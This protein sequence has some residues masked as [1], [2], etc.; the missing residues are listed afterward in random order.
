MG[1]KKRG[2][3]KK[4]FF[5]ITFMFAVMFAIN[6]AS[7]AITV[8]YPLNY[9]NYTGAFGPLVFFNVSYTNGTDF[10]DAVNATF[11][12]NLTGVW[13]KLGSATVCSRGATASSCN[14]SLNLSGVTDG[15]YSINATL[16][17]TTTSGA[18][19]TNNYTL[20]GASVV[21]QNII[22]DSTPPVVSFSGITN[23]INNGNYSQTMILNVSSTSPLMPISSVYFNITNSTGNQVN[24]TKASASGNYFNL[25]VNTVGFADGLYNVTVFS[26]DTLNN[27][28]NTGK[29]QIAIVNT[30]PIVSFS[31]ITN[32][33]NN[34][35]YS[36]TMVLNV[37][38]N[39]SSLIALSSVYFN[40]TNSSGTQIN[41]TK[42][43]AIGNY[44]NLSVNTVGFTDGLYN[45]TVFSNDTLNNLNNT[46]KIQFTIDNTAPTGTLTCSPN[47]IH[48]NYVLTCSCSS[49]D[50]TSGL[51]MTKGNVYTLNPDTS[52]T[53]TFTT[54]CS[55][56]DMAGNTGSASATYSVFFTA[57][58][59]GGG[60]SGSSTTTAQN[61]PITTTQSFST[62]SPTAPVTMSNF[63]TDT[64]K[65]IQVEVSQTATNVKLSVDRYDT[66][67][68]NVSVDKAN[69]YKYLH[70]D[71]QNLSDKLSRAIMSIQVNKSWTSMNGLNRD[72]ISLFR[73]N[74]NTN[75]WDKLTTT[76][77]SEDSNYYKYDA[78]LDH[79]SY[80]AI[81]SNKIVV[82]QTPATTTTQPSAPV[83]SNDYWIWI[84]AV[85]VAA[86]IIFVGLKLF[87]TGK[88]KKLFGF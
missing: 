72:E 33:I 35:N 66:K 38:S 67:P 46:G 53:G 22:F 1:D 9:S 11:Y 5:L 27:L 76:F 41:F 56:A 45:V 61:T 29:I 59:S 7:A 16:A 75:Q 73:F 23:T 54:S 49:S 25:S 88:R 26:N 68:A 50:A 74:E 14:V 82:S 18:S 55:F 37:S 48:Q 64:V 4:L 81:A 65:Q 43:S 87:K 42:A 10:T 3:G 24:F 44:F 58:S 86:A 21:T 62:I 36:Q 12:Y 31:G 2:F 32:T 69:T 47:S 63:G 28:N 52:Q 78:Q 39:S 19:A 40:I 15:I 17:N 84:I 80:F 71:T 34:G 77:T 85:I 6:S 13:T 79:F 70:V 30:A 60:G 57:T 83:S 20:Y 51:N 8:I